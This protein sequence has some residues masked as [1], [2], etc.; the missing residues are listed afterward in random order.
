MLKPWLPKRWRRLLF[1]VHWRDRVIRLEICHDNVSVLLK[2][3]SRFR[4]RVHFG[5]GALLFLQTSYT[6]S[7]MIRFC[8]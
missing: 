7:A 3:M 8:V 1:K 2:P 6:R 4:C 5:V